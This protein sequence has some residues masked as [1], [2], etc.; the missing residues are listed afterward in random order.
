MDDFTEPFAEHSWTAFLAKN[1]CIAA[2]AFELTSCRN[3]GSCCCLP[4]EILSGTRP[5]FIKMLSRQ[6][7][8]TVVEF[9]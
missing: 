9:L 1:T 2:L 6:A 7:A 3:V 4:F 8:Y 5:V